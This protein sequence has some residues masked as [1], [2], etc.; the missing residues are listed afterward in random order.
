MQR[1]K[2][3]VCIKSNSLNTFVFQFRYICCCTIKLVCC[4]N[5]ATI[6]CSHSLWSL[7]YA[8]V[9]CC[10]HISAF[11]SFFFSVLCWLIQREFVHDD[12]SESETKLFESKQSI[13]YFESRMLSSL[14]PHF[15]GINKRSEQQ[16]IWQFHK[17]GKCAHR[18]P[19]NASIEFT[20]NPHCEHKAVEDAQKNMIQAAHKTL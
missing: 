11:I 1:L 8:V 19:L 9:T 6:P 3:I 18:M 4:L 16:S 15:N 2:L 17:N 10:V 5:C 12:L 7:I 20:W 13:V 14:A